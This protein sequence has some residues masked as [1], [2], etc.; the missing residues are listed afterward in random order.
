VLL[1]NEI[2]DTYGNQTGSL[3]LG[4]FAV[5]IAGQPI[6][7]ATLTVSINNSNW[8][9]VN[10]STGDFALGTSVELLAAPAQYCRFVEWT[11]DA[12]GSSNSASVLVDSDKSV[13]AVFAEIT[14]VN[15]PTPYSWLASCGFTNDFEN[16]ISQIG[17]NGIP[18]WQSY[19]AGLNPNDPNSQFRAEVE[20]SANPGAYVVCWNTASNRVY[21]LYSSTSLFG[22]FESVPGAQRLP[23]TVT[24]FTNPVVGS[25]TGFYRILVELEQ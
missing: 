12:A 21:T 8:G 9:S 7:T 22:T 14:T 20:P 25:A 5:S 18:V 19:V 1:A 4:S 6:Q 23:W 17:A 13:G 16:A 15:N 10:P 24:S 3:T 2:E 11:G